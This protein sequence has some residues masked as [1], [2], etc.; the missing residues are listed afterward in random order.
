MRSGGFPGQKEA[1]R[2]AM[3]ARLRRQRRRW[4]AG[5]AA[6][7][8]AG[9]GG[10]AG[11]LAA[12]GKEPGAELPRELTWAYGLAL[13]DVDELVA[14]GAAFLAVADEY[15]RDPVLAQGLLRLGLRCLADPSPRAGDL[16]YRLIGTLR[17]AKRSPEFDRLTSLL[18]ERAR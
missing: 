12:W 1:L 9:A 14:R 11:L 15:P 16:I 17:A 10:A 18:E 8:V 5:A 13:G 3:R 4:L 7:F 2:S 6:A